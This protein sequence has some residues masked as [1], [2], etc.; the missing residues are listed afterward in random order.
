LTK[1]DLHVHSRHSGKPTN[2]LAKQYNIPECYTQPIHIYESALKKGLTHVTITDHDSLGGSLDI[3]HLPNTFLS[4][5]LTARFPEDQCKVHILTYNI[6]EQQFQSLDR[7]RKNIYELVQYLDENK[8]WHAIAHPFYSVNSKL[9]QQHFE[10]LLVM[11]DLFELNGFRSKAVNDRLRH[12]IKNISQEKLADL[13]TE[14]GIRNPKLIPQNK[15]FVSGS[16]DHCGLYVANSYTINPSSTLDGFFIAAQDNITALHNVE[17]V[18][19][20]YAVYSIVYQSLESR[21]DLD[22]YIRTDEALKNISAFMGRSSHWS[23]IAGQT[24]DGEPTPQAEIRR[25]DVEQLLRGIFRGIKVTNDDLSLE[26]AST[27]WFTLIS[28]AV[29][30]SVKDLLEY[31]VEQLKKGNIFNIFRTIGSISSLYFLC[32][33][34][35]ISYRV[36]QETKTFSAGVDIVDNPC[37]E[38]KVAHFTDTYREVNGVAFTL[39]QMMGCARRLGLDYEFITCNDT[40]GIHDEK[41]FHPI[42][43]FDLPEYPELKLA[44]PPVLDVL[45]YVYRGNFTHIHSATPGPVGLVG[46]LL[47]KLLKKPFYA[48]YHT[49]VPQYVGK[50]TDDAVLESMARKY[51]SWFYRMADRVFVPSDAFILELTKNDVNREKITLMPRGVDTE[52]FWFRNGN[53]CHEGYRLLYVGRISKEKNLHILAEAFKLLDRLDTSLTIVGDG[54]YLDALRDELKDYNV[55]FRGYLAGDMLVKAY[56]ESDLFVF[57]S[58]TD[59]FGNVI[60]EA[61]ACGLATIATDM[62]GPCENILNGETGL[63]VKGDDAAALT[64]GIESLLDRKKLEA[65]GKRAREVV[66]RRSFENEFLEF[67]KFYLSEHRVKDRI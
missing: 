14:Y 32:V 48:T 28:R 15:A 16:D 65:M 12:I 53:G 57:P 23:G 51:I 47:A 49:A 56:H 60:L 41:V 10:Q 19:L 5:E 3:A 59:T 55:D 17:A 63:I 38:P 58:A 44:F 37:H 26:N 11:F 43:V 21:L 45:D 61:H 54:P 66:E 22:K 40:P 39:R 27:Q 31:T 1:C 52:R 25:G 4:C 29:N 6:T 33:P 20:G 35:Y 8:I 24:A 50:L 42:S 46:L 30:E 64:A 62:G 9:T 18:D 7:L 36:F 13:A 34:Y 67:W 2:W